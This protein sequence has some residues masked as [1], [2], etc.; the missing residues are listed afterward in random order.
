MG[1]KQKLGA[2][3][4]YPQGISRRPGDE[5]GLRMAISDR[6]SEGL[7]HIDFGKQVAWLALPAPQAV[8]FAKLLMRKAG[9]KKITVEF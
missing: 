4:D 9:A 1:D 5:G 8:E 7:I 6:D 3:G 2:T